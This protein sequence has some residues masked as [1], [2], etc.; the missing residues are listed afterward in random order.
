M[1]SIDRYRYYNAQAE[2]PQVKPMNTAVSQFHFFVAM[3]KFLGMD[4]VMAQKFIRFDAHSWGSEL[5]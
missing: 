3:I 1:E 5:V 2:V 4:W